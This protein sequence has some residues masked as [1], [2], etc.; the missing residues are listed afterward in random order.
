M[1]DTL[2]SEFRKLLTVRSTYV[3]TGIALLMVMFF[4]F[5]IEGLRSNQATLANPDRLAG[6]VTDAISATAGLL[7]FVGLLLF[8]HEYRHNTI[9]YT[10]AA[11]RSRTRVLLA[12]IIVV[13]VF[14]LLMSLIVSVLSPALMYL[15]TQ[16]KGL[17]LAPQTLP[18]WDLLWRSLFYGWANS[19]VALL[20]A[21]LIRNQVGAIA[22]LFLIPGPVEMLFGLLLKHNMVYLPFTALQQVIS[23]GQHNGEQFMELRPLSPEGD[24]AVFCIYLAVGWLVAWFLFLR[25]DAN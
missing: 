18:V 15:G 14:V 1:K 2:K 17:E 20:L 16:I 24:A 9:T 4:G 10:L 6:G 13:S 25:R 11:S 8:T 22:A 19:M 21:G 7:S 5:Y 12:K 3:I 23:S